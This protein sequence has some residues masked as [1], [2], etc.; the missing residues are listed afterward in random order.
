M[1]DSGIE[2][3][4]PNRVV[5]ILVVLFFGLLLVVLGA[6]KWGGWQ[7]GEMGTDYPLSAVN[8]MDSI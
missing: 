5:R 7:D 4:R 8:D 3:I 2:E 1:K 6:M